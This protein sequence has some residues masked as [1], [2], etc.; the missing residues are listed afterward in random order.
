MTYK[1]LKKS[2]PSSLSATCIVGTREHIP[3]HESKKI[4]PRNDMGAK[5]ANCK[6]LYTSTDG[7]SNLN[8]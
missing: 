5:L 1:H 8:W 3:F 6:I 7:Q 2:I 4:A